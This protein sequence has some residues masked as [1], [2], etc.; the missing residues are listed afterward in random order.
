MPT[1]IRKYW[2]A[3]QGR[4]SLN[5]NWPIIEQDSTVIVTISEYTAEK[6][7][8][9]GAAS[10]TI[11][12]IAPHGPPNDPNHGVSFVVNVN[13]SSPVNIVTDITVLDNKPVEVDFYSP[14]APQNIGL[15]MQYQESNEWCWIASA[16]SINHFYNPASTVTQCQIMTTVGQNINKFPANTS[17]CPSSAVIFA[18]PALAAALA[19]P[20]TKAA[21]YILDDPKYGI[22]TYYLKSGGVGDAL[23]VKANW[24]GPQ[25]ANLSLSEIASE[26]NAGRPVCASIAWNSGNGQHVV[27]IAG[28]SGNNLL[29]LD[30]I[31]GQSV[32]PFASFPAY[33]YGGATIVGY[34][35]TKK[36]S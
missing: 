15:R 6:I 30:P 25:G 16:T 28:V 34:D 4:N 27:T 22:P 5:Y 36:G 31:N 13:W 33:Y 20:Y 19:N 18:N 23:N 35:F 3:F 32:L 8:F 12:N 17:A 10:L 1:T 24:A 2:G 14:P 21:E 7:R 9:I 26:V 29:L 11:S